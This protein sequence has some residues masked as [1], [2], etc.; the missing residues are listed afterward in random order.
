M[1]FPGW[2]SVAYRF[3][4]IEWQWCFLAG[5][6]W[7]MDLL[8]FFPTILHN[9]CTSEAEQLSHMQRLASKVLLTSQRL[10]LIRVVGHCLLD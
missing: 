4:H 10:H 9:C 3:A 6:V 8:D 2:Y 5:T 1:V 7:C